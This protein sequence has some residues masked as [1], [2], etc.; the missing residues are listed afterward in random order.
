MSCLQ[1]TALLK[2][3]S[4]MTHLAHEYN[5]HTNMKLCGRYTEEKKYQYNPMAPQADTKLGLCRKGNP[6][7]CYSTNTIYSDTCKLQNFS[8]IITF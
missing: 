6:L 4:S 1:S 7:C 8:A 3:H 2:N 5:E